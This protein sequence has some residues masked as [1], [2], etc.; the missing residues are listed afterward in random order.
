MSL[1]GI[2]KRKAHSVIMGRPQKSQWEPWFARRP[3]LSYSASVAL[4]AGGI[5]LCA[6]GKN[7]AAPIL[8]I[9]HDQTLVLGRT[10][11]ARQQPRPALATIGIMLATCGTVVFCRVHLLGSH[12][13]GEQTDGGSGSVTNL[14]S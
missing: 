14:R 4:I 12:P 9:T 5:V 10:P 2:A 13:A 1:L 3:S 6:W 11:A 8:I 7:D